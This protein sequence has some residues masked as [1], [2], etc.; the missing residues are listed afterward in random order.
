[1]GRLEPEVAFGEFGMRELDIYRGRYARVAKETTLPQRTR[2]VVMV[3]SMLS[4]HVCVSAA[5][6]DSE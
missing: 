1:V 2:S 3:P 5:R 6:V 4:F